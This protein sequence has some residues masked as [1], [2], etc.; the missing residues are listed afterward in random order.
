VPELREHADTSDPD[1]ILVGTKLDLR[2]SDEHLAEMKKEGETPI[3]TEM[4]QALSKES[5]ARGYFEISALT[6]EG[7]K[8]VFDA[9]AK[10]VVDK[11]NKEDGAENSDT[12]Q[13]KSKGCCILM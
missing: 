13:P 12:P 7:L 1:F 3:S 10:I 4:G 5:G 6:Q 2:A 9:A 11:F 8:E